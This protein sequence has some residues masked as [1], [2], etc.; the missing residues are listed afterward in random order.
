MIDWRDDGAILAAQFE[1]CE[2]FLQ[3]LITE[4]A[5]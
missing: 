3:R 5:A 4:L 2:A 1:A